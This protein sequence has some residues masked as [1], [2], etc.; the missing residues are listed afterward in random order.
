MLYE[1]AVFLWKGWSAGSMWSMFAGVA[2][3]WDNSN[4]VGGNDLLT[5]TA[6]I[7]ATESDQAILI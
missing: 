4:P 6:I 3:A 2:H 1:I 7:L 5:E